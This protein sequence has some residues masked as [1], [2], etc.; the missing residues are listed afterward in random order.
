MLVRFQ[1][2]NLFTIADKKWK[3]LDPETN[4]ANIPA[5]PTYS[6]G[7][8]CVFLKIGRYEKVSVYIL[9]LFLPWFLSACDDYLKEDSDDLLIPS[10]VNDY[11][12]ILLGE[13]YPMS[14]RPQIEWIHLMTDDVRW[15]RYIMT[16]RCITIVR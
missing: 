9:I 10:L 16:S 14:L 6:F 15:A 2:M 12:L 4:G 3:G 11:V 1:V 13:G 5:L 7:D 8:K